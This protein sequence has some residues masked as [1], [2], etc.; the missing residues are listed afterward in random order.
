MRLMG[1]PDTR[2]PAL[3]SAGW[4]DTHF[5]AC[6]GEYLDMVRS[7]GFRPGWHVLDA[8]CGNGSFLPA[9][10]EL[11]G[12]LGAITA[13]DV[14]VEHVSALPD[15]TGAPPNECGL[16][17]RSGQL[18]ALPLADG[19]VDGVWC[20]NALQYL[21]D[22]K[23]ETALLELRRVTRPGGLVAVKDVDMLLTRMGPG[24]PTLLNRLADVCARGPDAS[25]HSQGSI[26]G[27]D[28]RRWLERAGLVDVWQRSVLIE[29]WAPLQPA[30]RALWDDWLV[31]LAHVACAQELPLEDQVSW[32]RLTDPAV[33]GSFLDALDFYCCEGQVLAVGRVQ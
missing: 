8:G 20:A 3:S 2:K 11:V 9:L 17:A 33:R 16:R 26:R 32:S 14:D 22:G 4:L 23:A 24:D 10:A 7:A 15:R 1:P 27:R 21:D 28:L 25:P 13:V 29:R 5:D 30:E 12:P 6:R 31:H 18:T 19:E